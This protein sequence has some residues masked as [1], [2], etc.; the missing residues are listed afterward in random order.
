MAIQLSAFSFQ[1]SGFSYNDSSI[2]SGLTYYYWVKAVNS[3]GTSAF[4]ACDTGYPG[5]IGPLVS[6]N[7]MV[8]DNVV[9]SSGAPITIAVEMMNVDPWAGYKVDWWVAAYARES[10]LWL[11]MN[12]DMAWV[13]FDGQLQNI[14]PAYQGPLGNLSQ[15]EIAKDLVL[16][17]GIYNIWF[18]VD[19]P[20]DGILDINGTILMSRVSLTVE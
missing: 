18:A 7:G 14:R 10:E 17:P 1:V 12:S 6:A 5:V 8:G 11:Y 19:Y 3:A 20:M 15:V 2:A 9:V 16:A 4:S 13:E